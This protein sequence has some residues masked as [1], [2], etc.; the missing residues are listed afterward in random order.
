MKSTEYNKNFEKH[1]TNILIH[2]I[3]LTD[4]LDKTNKRVIYINIDEMYNKSID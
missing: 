1:Y 2:I 3:I 4:T